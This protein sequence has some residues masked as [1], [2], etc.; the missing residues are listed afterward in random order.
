MPQLL[1]TVAN[2]T[3]RLR[4]F[5]YLNSNGLYNTLRLKQLDEEMEKLQSTIEATH[6]DNPSEETL[7][8]I[9]DVCLKHKTIN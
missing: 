3:E 7:K 8:L 5:Q 4:P 6:N 2:L 9:T 1:V